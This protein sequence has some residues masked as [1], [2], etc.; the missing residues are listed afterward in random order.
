MTESKWKYLTDV[1]KEE[2]APQWVKTLARAIAPIQGACFYDNNL[3][4]QAAL[5][6]IQLTREAL[7]LAEIEILEAL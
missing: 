3:D 5:Y 1:A 6:V 2:D 7:E 4:K